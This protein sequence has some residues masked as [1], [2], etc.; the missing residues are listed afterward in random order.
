MWGHAEQLLDEYRARAPVRPYAR[1]PVRARAA[2]HKMFH[3]CTR[4][5]GGLAPPFRTRARVAHG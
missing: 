1:A 3:L 4:A 2:Q 5:R